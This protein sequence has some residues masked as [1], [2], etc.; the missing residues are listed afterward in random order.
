[1]L[2]VNAFRRVLFVV[3]AGAL[4]ALAP[5]FAASKKDEN[6][7]ATWA[8][9]LVTAAGKA[10]VEQLTLSVAVTQAA[11]R[12][13]YSSVGFEVI[14]REPRALKIGDRYV[15]EDLMLLRLTTND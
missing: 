2:S 4:V 1:M 15:D 6:W 3:V 13:L 12:H 8:T 7:V 5:A 10:G 14:G 11:A 9:A